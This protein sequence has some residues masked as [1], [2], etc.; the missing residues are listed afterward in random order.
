MSN[1]TGKRDD[2]IDYDSNEDDQ[3]DNGGDD[4]MDEGENIHAGAEIPTAVSP[5]KRRRRTKKEIMNST[6]VS[7]LRGRRKRYTMPRHQAYSKLHY[8]RLRPVIKS[9]WKNESHRLIQEDR[10]L[11]SLRGAALSRA[12]NRQKLAFTNRELKRLYNNESDAVKEE[13]E[14]FRTNAAADDDEDDVNTREM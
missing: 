14:A 9:A 8:E 13:V 12:L 10:R 5:P 1:H 11:R 6:I 7:L 2:G 4:D 3:D